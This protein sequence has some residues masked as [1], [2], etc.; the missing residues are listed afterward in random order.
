MARRFRASCGGDPAGR[1]AKILEPAAQL[2]VQAVG[3]TSFVKPEETYRAIV[4]L[5][6]VT[7]WEV[8]EEASRK[9]P[10][11]FPAQHRPIYLSIGNI[12]RELVRQ[13]DYTASVAFER[14]CLN[15]SSAVLAAKR[16]RE[17]EP[18]QRSKRAKY[19]FSSLAALPES[20]NA[21][22]L[23]PSSQHP[24]LDRLREYIQKLQS[25]NVG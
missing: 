15:S 21:Y 9:L 17:N 24:Q 13:Y 14:D 7:D 3:P 4:G 5:L 6:E 11:E 1:A 25:S 18:V 23:V 8:F 2:N 22:D 16:R 20:T 10:F 12:I 19:F